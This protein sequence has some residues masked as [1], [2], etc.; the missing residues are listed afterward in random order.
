MP[1]SSSFPPAR[2]EVRQRFA[3]LMALRRAVVASCITVKA[4]V[5]AW[6]YTDC[7]NAGSAGETRLLDA[8]SLMRRAACGLS[9]SG[10]S[11]RGGRSSTR[12]DDA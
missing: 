10:Y 8:L 4:K 2:S 11:E 5:F 7:V 12:K 6:G 9:Q 1:G 3:V